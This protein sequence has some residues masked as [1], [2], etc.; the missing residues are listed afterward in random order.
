MFF[1]RKTPPTRSEL[2][3]QAD[4]ARAKGKV[5]K[6]IAGYRKA[7]ELEPGDAMVHGKLAPL[8]ARTNAAGAALESFRAAAKAHLDKGFADKAVAVYAQAA[9]TLPL[10]PTLWQQLAQLQVTR[11]RRADAVKAL[12]RGRVHF[13]RKAHRRHAISLL[14][15]ALSLD[16]ELFAPKLDLARLLAREGA[17]A[18]AVVLLEPLAKTM[19]GRPL[20]QVR[21]ALARVAPGPGAYWRWMRAVLLGR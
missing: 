10:E 3:A 4:K 5:K 1:R 6:A 19:K 11:G 13:R 8:L 20:R 9:D 16:G 15:E 12:L 7:L 17:R 21:W 14:K 2:I 18:E